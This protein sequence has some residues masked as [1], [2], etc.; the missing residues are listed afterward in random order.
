[1]RYFAVLGTLAVV[2]G[3]GGLVGACRPSPAQ[4]TGPAAVDSVTAPTLTVADSARLRGPR[5]PIFFRHDRHAG[6]F[7]MPCMYCHH[8]V[9]V[10]NEPGIPSVETCMGCH[11]VIAGTDSSSR[12]EI[13][14]LRDFW[15][16][17]DSAG[18]PRLEWVRVHSVARHAHFPHNVHI[19][20]LGP[21][22]CMACHGD[23]ARMPRVWEVNNVNNMGF[24][25]QCHLERNVS[26]DCSVCHY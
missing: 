11:R 13:R 10:S 14:R 24:C 7:K 2:C 3:G 18:A 19:K 21:V 12:A 6:Q 15:N 23:V 8:A 22:G 25:I 4:E 17:R 16:T 9:K 1:M 5:Q 20:A 26:R